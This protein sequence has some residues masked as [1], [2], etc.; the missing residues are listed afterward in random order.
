MRLQLPMSWAHWLNSLPCVELTHPP[1]LQ[2]I[3]LLLLFLLLLRLIL[4][5]TLLRMVALHRM[6]L[7]RRSEA[8][9]RLVSRLQ[10]I[11]DTIAPSNHAPAIP[12]HR[13]P[14]LIRMITIT[15]SLILHLLHL[16]L[17]IIPAAII[18]L[19]HTHNHHLSIAH[20]IQPHLLHI[21]RDTPRLPLL[22]QSAPIHLLL[23]LLL[24]LRRI[25]L[26][27]LPIRLTI[28][29]NNSI[30]IAIRLLLLLLAQP[31]ATHHLRRLTAA[32]VHTSTSSSS[33]ISNNNNTMPDFPQEGCMRH[34]VC[35]R[36]PL[37]L[38]LLSLFLMQQQ[39]QR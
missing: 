14:P 8:L 38:L 32:A 18:S 20:R 4:L 1:H 25:T 17:W 22:Q 10:Q 39:I 36:L 27:Q 12:A 33:S 6:V 11:A 28:N 15:S 29:H 24:H 5:R 34:Q 26:N 2:L 37:P 9:Q 23:L 35:L 30:H 19:L 7:L 21:P 3:F 16:L 31:R 13:P